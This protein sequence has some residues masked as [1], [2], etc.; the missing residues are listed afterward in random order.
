MATW[1]T[2]LL[3][4]LVPQ[5]LLLLIVSIPIYCGFKLLIHYILKVSKNSIDSAS[6]TF[7]DDHNMTCEKFKICTQKKMFTTP[8]LQCQLR[9][10]NKCKYDTYVI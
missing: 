6:F 4:K 3:L 7:S 2:I 10:P 8:S 9:L 1:T 5:L